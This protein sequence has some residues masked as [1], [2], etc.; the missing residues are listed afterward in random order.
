MLAI[1]FM[2]FSIIF[3]W[4]H[5]KLCPFSRPPVVVV[6]N[7][8]V[9]KKGSLVG[10]PI[11]HPVSYKP[12]MTKSTAAPLTS[13]NGG[14]NVVPTISPMKNTPGQLLSSAQGRPGPLA[15]SGLTSSLA[16]ASISSPVASRPA[17][18]SAS[19]P[20]FGA[21]KRASVGGAGA[22][23]SVANTSFGAGGVSAS[24]AVTKDRLKAIAS[25]NPYLPRYDIYIVHL[26]IYMYIYITVIIVHDPCNARF[27]WM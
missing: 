25:L 18:G 6:S 27:V 15:P 22:S 14:S 9:I 19:A 17:L 4:V 26:Y 1:D 2:T 7:V 16:L 24:Q 11:G 10:G 5:I 12:D 13:H 21:G 3:S 8:K 20:G 23:T